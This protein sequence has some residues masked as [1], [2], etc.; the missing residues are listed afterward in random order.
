MAQ[1]QAKQASTGKKPGGK[2]PKP[3]QTEPQA[4][5]Q[6]NL[7]DEDSR[8]MKVAGGG[9]EQCYNAQ[10]VVDTESMLV[11]APHVT[12]AGND[13]AQ[14]APMLERIQALPDGLNQPERLL[15]NLPKRRHPRQMEIMII[16]TLKYI[17]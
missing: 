12:T 2:P 1:R 8:I 17:N 14:V 5:D 3:P 6:I 7:T 16:M 9:F 4:E 10:A 15:A 13:K 11:L